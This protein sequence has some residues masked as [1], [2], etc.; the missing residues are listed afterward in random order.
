MY[1][2]ASFHLLD[3]SVMPADF[4]SGSTKNRTTSPA[5]TSSDLNHLRLGTNKWDC[6]KNIVYHVSWT[7]FILSSMAAVLIIMSHF[8]GSKLGSAQVCCQLS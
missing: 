4:S 8:L 5:F 3:K 7:A 1:K 6:F 2:P